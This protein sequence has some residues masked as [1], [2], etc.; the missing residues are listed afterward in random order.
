MRSVRNPPKQEGGKPWRALRNVSPLLA[1]TNFSARCS[2]GCRGTKTPTLRSGRSDFAVLT[3]PTK[4]SAG[5]GQKR[6][7]PLEREDKARPADSRIRPRLFSEQER[8][9]SPALGS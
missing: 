4:T 5:R 6:K 9:F 7:T 2:K 3:T 8:E 1:P